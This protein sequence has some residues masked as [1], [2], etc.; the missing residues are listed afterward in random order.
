MVYTNVD[1]VR[2]VEE[3]VFLSGSYTL[4]E[5]LSPFLS[6]SAMQISMEAFESLSSSA[7]QISMEAFESLEGSYS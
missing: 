5:L 7:M 4:A 3:F 1:V 2:N 6:S